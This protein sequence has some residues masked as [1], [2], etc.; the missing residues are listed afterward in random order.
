MSKKNLILVIGRSGSGKDT[1]V[2]RAMIPFNAISVPSYTDR[3]IRPT[4]VNGREHTF[5]TKEQ[6]D[7]VMRTEKVFAYTKIGETGYRYCTTVE[8]LRRF[9]EENI[10]YIIDPEGFYFCQKFVNEFNM[11]CIYVTADDEL[12]KARANRRNGDTTAWE[13]RNKDEDDQFTLFE[14]EKR[15]DGIVINNGSLDEALEEFIRCTSRIL[16]MNVVTKKMNV[17]TKKITRP[18]FLIRFNG[19]LEEKYIE[20]YGSAKNT[21]RIHYFDA[22][23]FFSVMERLDKEFINEQEF[24]VWDPD[25]DSFVNTTFSKFKTVT[26]M[27]KYHVKEYV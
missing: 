21:N 10:F 2:R 4:E 22:E 13:K 1:L 6:F 16:N 19:L 20:I 17:G 25:E 7:E 27:S 26:D 11:K 12:R 5:L 18:T 9:P 8:M 3:P 14:L 23:S 15:W 24:C